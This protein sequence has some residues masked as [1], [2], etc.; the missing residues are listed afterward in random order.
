M[1]TELAQ[2]RVKS[3]DTEWDSEDGQT[4]KS[5]VFIVDFK[6]EKAPVLI[7]ATS[8]CYYFADVDGVPPDDKK[9]LTGF[10]SRFW[11][12]DDD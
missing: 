10:V 9:A 4:G 3:T 12:E 8:P 6:T 11:N 1:P 5:G 2:A 7:K